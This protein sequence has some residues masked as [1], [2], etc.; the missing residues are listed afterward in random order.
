MFLVL[1]QL[2]VIELI[3][4][5]GFHIVETMILGLDFMVQM[6]SH[7][8]LLVLKDFILMLMETL[9]LTVKIHEVH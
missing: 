6:N 5:L 3:L 1:L 2:V 4:L 8:K 7:L 9:V